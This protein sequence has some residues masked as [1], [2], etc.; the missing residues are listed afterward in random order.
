M[1][2]EEEEVEEMLWVHH[3]ILGSVSS[4]LSELN[5]QTELIS[6]HRSISFPFQRGG[7]VWEQIPGFFRTLNVTFKLLLPR[8][9]WPDCVF[10]EAETQQEEGKALCMASRA[11]IVLFPVCLL[12][13]IK[14]ECAFS[15]SFFRSFSSV[16]CNKSKDMRTMMDVSEHTDI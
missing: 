15:L 7:W 12:S 1:S 8:R 4:V 11:C 9:S 10:S 2:E 5:R 6:T 13:V 14:A 16:Q 3:Y